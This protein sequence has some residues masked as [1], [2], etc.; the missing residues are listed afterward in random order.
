MASAITMIQIFQRMTAIPKTNGIYFSIVKC[1]DLT[2]EKTEYHYSFIE[3]NDGWKTPTMDGYTMEIVAWTELENP[4]NHFK[5][6]A[7]IITL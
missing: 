6:K 1:G 7:K 2:T 5:E 4:E 3:Y